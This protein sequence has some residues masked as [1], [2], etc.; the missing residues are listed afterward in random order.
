VTAGN[1]VWVAPAA[2]LYVHD[3][4]STDVWFFVVIENGVGSPTIPATITSRGSVF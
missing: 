1:A 2:P 4:A 3:G